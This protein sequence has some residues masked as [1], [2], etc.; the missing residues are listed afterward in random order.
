MRLDT[1]NIDIGS[2]TLNL[3]AVTLVIQEA[4][5]L[6]PPAAFVI[7]V[8]LEEITFKDIVISKGINM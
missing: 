3:M 5:R 7:I 8:A 4:L 1:P 6:Y 2:L